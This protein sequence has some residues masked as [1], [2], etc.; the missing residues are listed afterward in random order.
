MHSEKSVRTQDNGEQSA[1]AIT[2]VDYA[3]SKAR[4]AVPFKK[5]ASNF[6]QGNK[7][8]QA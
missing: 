8:I 2:T 1:E 3:A 4:G 7:V 5:S 6:I